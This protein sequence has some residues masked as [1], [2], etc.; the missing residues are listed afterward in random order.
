MLHAPRFGLFER[1]GVELEYMIVDAESLAV[2]PISDQLLFEIAGDYRSEVEI[3]PIAWSNELAMHVIELKTSSPAASFAP[4]ASLFQNHVHK[5]NRLL[6]SRHARLMPTAMH[7]WMD[8]DRELHLWPHE[9]N[10][11]YESL[12]RIF[13]CKGH[14]WANLQ[15][16]HLNLPFATEAEFGRLHAAIRLLLPILPAIAASSPVVEGQV[17]PW[18]DTRLEVYRQNSQRI[19]SITGRV[20]PEPVFTFADYENQILNRMYDDIRPLDPDGTLQ[21]EWLNSRGAIARFDR[22]T[23]E[24]RLLDLQECPAAD[25]AICQAIMLVLRAMTDERWTKWGEQQ[26]LPIEPLERILLDAIRDADRAIIH[27]RQ[28]VR[29]FGRDDTSLT[30][31]EL[32]RHLIEAIQSE[33]QDDP[34]DAPASVHIP[35]I[36]VLR[37]I[38]EEG[39]L[40]RRILNE[41]A[42][43]VDRIDPLYCQLCRCLES[44][45]MLTAQSVS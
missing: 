35:P 2:R 28:Y 13:N 36:T 41:L 20:I 38:V 19:P 3:G 23:I 5:I 24:I 17:T 9:Y 34:V 22:F 44:G 4:L 32:W 11:V 45:K 10:P 12:N 14:G 27:D 29:Q 16:V 37:T 39:P 31:G 30:T 26:Q 21:H 6:E 18:A 7:P 42:G 33:L 8:P 1:I 25:L 43:D 40:A 15:S